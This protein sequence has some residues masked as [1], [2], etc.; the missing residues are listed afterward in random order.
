MDHPFLPGTVVAI[1][2]GHSIVETTVAKVHK[3][4]NFTLTHRSEANQQWKASHWGNKWMANRTGQSIRSRNEPV[5]YL[6]DDAFRVE[7]ASRKT[8]QALV[9][10]AHAALA[11]V[12]NA[13]AEHLT[14][15]Q[16]EALEQFVR[17]YEGVK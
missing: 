16:V 4:G 12:N 17:L 1:D 7:Y 5:V 2:F 15:W 11:K 6:M 14:E 3:N 13:R 10:R 8:K 9:K